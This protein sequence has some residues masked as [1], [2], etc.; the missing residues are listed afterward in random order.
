MDHAT[1]PTSTPTSSTPRGPWIQTWSGHA[2]PLI[3]PAPSDIRRDDIVAALAKI[4]RFTG[5]TLEPYS[6]AQ[7]SL[8]VADLVTRYSDH[9]DAVRYA[10]LHDAHEAYI[11]DESTPMKWARVKIERATNG[12]GTFAH[13][14]LRGGIDTAIWTAFGLD[15][16]VEVIMA[17][18]QADLLALMVERRDL[19]NPGPAWEGNYP[20]P[21]GVPRIQPLNWRAAAI[22]FDAALTRHFG[23]DAGR[24]EG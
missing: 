19:M 6:V 5:H 4:N 14:Q 23:P 20:D 10:L 3:A 17:A 7:H 18:K 24:G 8:L 15:P 12:A 1:L 2:F 13:G 16:S 22:A 9:P 11:G 21:D